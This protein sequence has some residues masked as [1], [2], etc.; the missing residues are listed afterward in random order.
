METFK[1]IALT[2][3]ILA[4]ILIF[5]VCTLQ[6][7]DLVF[8]DN[9]QIRVLVDEEIVYEG[10]SGGVHT[11]SRGANTFVKIKKGFLYLFP[12]S[13]HVGKNVRIENI[14]I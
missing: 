12:Q 7:I 13:Y 11:E 2:T 1:L 4:L 6:A 5:T 3:V 14:G 9:V 8:F 10:I